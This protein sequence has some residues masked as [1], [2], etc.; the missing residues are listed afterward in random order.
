YHFQG[1]IRQGTNVTVSVKATSQQGEK[2]I[3]LGSITL[4]DSQGNRFMA[5]PVGGLG[6]KI[7]IREGKSTLLS[8]KFANNALNGQSNA[9]SPRITTFS[10]VI[11]IEQR[12]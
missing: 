12:G 1:I 4:V 5:N 9:P 10:T 3:T 7:S 11:F 2:A 8:W 6:Q